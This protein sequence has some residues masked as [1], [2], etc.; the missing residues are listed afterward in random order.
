MEIIEL[1]LLPW[2]AEKIPGATSVEIL[3]S[4]FEKL[5]AEYLDDFLE[6]VLLFPECRFPRTLVPRKKL[7]EG[8]ILYYLTKLK[9]STTLP[10]RGINVFQEKF[11]KELLKVF[12]K[13]KKPLRKSLE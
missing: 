3:Q 9:I 13:K 7:K 12:Q 10:G 11:L 6:I 2:S 4:S 1:K 5:L 8:D